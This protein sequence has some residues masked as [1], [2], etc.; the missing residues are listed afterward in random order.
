M[1]NTIHNTQSNTEIDM[2]ITTTRLIRSAAFGLGKLFDLSKNS[3]LLHRLKSIKYI[4]YILVKALSKVYGGGVASDA[5]LL[6]RGQMPPFQFAQVKIC[7]LKTN[8]Q[9]ALCPP[10]H[11]PL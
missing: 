2:K 7:P 11:I 1:E 4:S 8:A 10:R 3:P 6:A 9:V 5:L